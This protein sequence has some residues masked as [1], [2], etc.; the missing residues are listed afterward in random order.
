MVS[1]KQKKFWIL[2]TG[3]AFIALNSVLIV[4][5]YYW[6]ALFPAGLLLVGLYFV[7]L[8]KVFLLVAFLTPLSVE[9]VIRDF[10][11]GISLPTEPLLIG[12]MII[13]VFKFL[14]HNPIPRYIWMHP[15]TILIVLNTAWMAFTSVTS[16]LPVVSLKYLVMQLWFIIPVFFV[17]VMVFKDERKMRQFLLLFLTSVAITVVYTTYQHYHRGFDGQAAHWVMYPFYN[18]HTAYGAVLAMVLPVGL[19]FILDSTYSRSIRIIFAAL[20]MII[21]IGLVLSVSRAAWL[22]AAAAL[23]FF[24][25]LYYR[26]KFKTLVIGG[27]VMLTVLFAF[28]DRIISRMERNTQESEE[29]DFAKHARS[30]SNI[31]TDA[32]NLE[33]LNR[34]SAALKMFRERP[35]V[36]WGPGTY[37]FVYASYQKSADLTIISTNFGDQGSVHSEYIGPLTHSGLPGML[38]FMALIISV[39]AVTLRVLHHEMPARMRWYLMAVFLGLTTYYVHGVLN[40]FLETDKAAVPFWGFTAIIVS[41]DIYHSYRKKGGQRISS[42]LPEADQLNAE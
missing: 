8:D 2:G 26:I 6:F 23:G 4:M 29:T 31:T 39:I 12:M 30:M 27:L 10:G 18:D 1:E 13:M 38:L 28:Q 40:D 37:Q 5:E 14:H 35:V 17:G 7:A 41:I 16:E 42:P 3:L 33:R 11:L 32:S 34:W 9:V 20:T 24:I 19:V 22:S 21:F 25:I 15:V 36:G